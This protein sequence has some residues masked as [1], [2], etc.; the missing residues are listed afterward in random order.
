MS[1]FAPASFKM[2]SV[3]SM[4]SGPMLSP[5]ATVIGTVG[6]NECLS[7]GYW[8]LTNIR[9]KGKASKAWRVC[10]C[11]QCEHDHI[12]ILGLKIDGTANAGST[13]VQVITLKSQ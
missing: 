5:C 13:H 8:K 10:L 1:S 6:M 2:N 7:L 4:I 9:L 12:G 3:A 11:N